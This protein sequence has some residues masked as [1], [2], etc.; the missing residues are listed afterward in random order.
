MRG[1]FSLMFELRQFAFPYNAMKSEEP[2]VNIRFV[3]GHIRTIRPIP[4]IPFPKQNKRSRRDGFAAHGVAVENGVRQLLMDFNPRAVVD[5]VHV[6]IRIDRAITPSQL[7]ST[8]LQRQQ[9]QPAVDQD[10]K[11]QR[12]QR[13]LEA[14]AAGRGV[15]NCV[16]VSGIAA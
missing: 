9:P 14:F 4:H 13:E 16:H 1:V 10:D 5:E 15:E 8:P 2:E 6:V 11:H 12:A 3:S 7:P